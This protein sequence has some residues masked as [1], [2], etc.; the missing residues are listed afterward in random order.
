MN[1][2][3]KQVKRLSASQIVALSFLGVIVLGTLL[4]FLPISSQDSAP[5]IGVVDAFFTATSAV[6][7]TGLVVAPTYAQWS[8]FGQIVI[9]MLIQ[10]GGLSF[11]VLMTFFSALLGRKIGL[12]SRLMVQ[13]A[14]NQN[15][16][17]GMV[18]IVMLAIKITFLLEGLGALVI[19]FAFLFQGVPPASAMYYGVFHAISAFCNAGFDVLG[20]D[21]L[22]P[23]V[24]NLPINLTVMALIVGGGLGFTVWGEFS[25][26][27]D[28]RFARDV[29]KRRKLS[30]HARLVLIA[31]GSL[32]LGGALFFFLAE[33][34]NPATLGPLS[35]PEK[36][37]A[38]FFQS[39]TLRTAGYMSIPQDG[40]K[41]SSKFVSSMFMMVGGSPGGT[42]GGFKTVTLIIV[43]VCVWAVIKGRDKLT[44]M[45]RTIP[46]RSLQ[47]ALAI[48]MIMV[49]LLFAITALLNITERES[50]F[51]H[52]FVDILFEVSSAL[53]T[54]GLTTGITPY[55][56]DFGKVVLALCMYIGRLGPVS[57]AVALAS[58]LK[59][60]PQLLKYPEE[61]VIVG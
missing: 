60:S 50:E 11:I 9:I 45:S 33:Y 22:I 38:S 31:T 59:A 44:I 29:I 40:L 21:S 24:G 14:F 2:P 1:A 42:A 12:R 4:L 10:I 39:V 43:F 55:L 5:D 34:N 16:F 8:T 36:I 46:Y 41:E 35:L 19:F 13:A 61:D 47:K 28:D 49:V 27:L 25:Q 20:P 7:V 56:T 32:I 57:I 51:E 6:C 18:R 54:V 30:I 26:K 48:M 17:Q 58:R 3:A 15:S 52:T 53:G 37:L 23:Y